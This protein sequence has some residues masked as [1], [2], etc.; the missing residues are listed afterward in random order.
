MLDEE[1]VDGDGAEGAWG[2]VRDVVV[3]QDEDVDDVDALPQ[4]DHGLSDAAHHA[5]D[6]P[7]VEGNIM[8]EQTI[9]Q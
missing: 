6:A 7:G 3:L 9:S 4:V 5:V 1:P 8:Y 2:E